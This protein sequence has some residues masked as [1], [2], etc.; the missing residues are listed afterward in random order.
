MTDAAD[1]LQRPPDVNNPPSDICETCQGG[2]IYFWQK[3]DAPPAT[4]PASN[5]TPYCESWEERFA[6]KNLEFNLPDESRCFDL[7]IVLR[8]PICYGMA[9]LER[10]DG[11]Y[12]VRC[13]GFPEYRKPCGNET[14]WCDTSQ[15]AVCAWKLMLAL[16]K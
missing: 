12:R 1:P 13:G 15:E 16:S 14:L 3:V 4:A 10:K 7:G 6:R 2:T 5:P 11:T 8:C 9:V